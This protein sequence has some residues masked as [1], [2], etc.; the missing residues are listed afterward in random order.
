MGRSFAR[1]RIVV[2]RCLGFEACRYDG[3][4]IPNDVIQALTRHVDIIAVCPEVEIGLGVPR[5]PI[6]LVQLGDQ[7]R[8]I[9]PDD[10]S[11]L[12][13]AMTD[14]AARFLSNL[15]PV[16]GFIL[17]N[18]SPSCAIRDAV[19]YTTG[20]GRVGTRPGVFAQAVLERFGDYPI[21]DEGRLSNRSIREHFFTAIFALA[22]LRQ[23]V[24]TGRMGAL[25]DFHTR[26]KLLL[27]AY[28][29]QRLRELGRLVANAENLPFATVAQEYARIFRLALKRPPRR[30]SVLNALMHAL[31]YVS[32]G[33]SKAE[34]AA[35]LELLEAYRKEKVPLS[36]PVALLRSWILR[37]EQHYLSQQAFFEPFPSDLIS[38]KDS[39]KPGGWV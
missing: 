8:L 3:S 2:S 25:V 5:P 26:F 7:A 31:G 18:R 33:L 28:N 12:T 17:K 15:P 16:D 34:K 1:P 37:F 14:F 32:E 23:T 35:F 22:E 29:Q 27:M 10:G 6:R 21:E 30:P 4:I 24:E 9:R 36:T 20:T 38:L 13:D 11:D 19:L 39:G